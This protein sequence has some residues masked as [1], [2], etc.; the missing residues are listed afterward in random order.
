MDLDQVT[1]ILYIQLQKF[2]LSQEG[3]LVKI[4]LI[5]GSEAILLTLQMY[6]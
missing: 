4:H 1:W 3:D 5:A 2:I 6:A